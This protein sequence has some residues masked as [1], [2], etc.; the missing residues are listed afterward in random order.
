MPRPKYR[1]PAKKEHTEK[2]ESFNFGDAW[3]R[4]S[5]VSEY[6]PHGSRMPSR[7]GSLMSRKSFGGRSMRSIGRPSLARGDSSEGKKSIGG[8]AVKDEDSR[9]VESREM[10]ENGP[11]VKKQYGVA[12]PTR[13]SVEVEQEGDDDVANGKIVPIRRVLPCPVLQSL[14]RQTGQ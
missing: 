12:R 14:A 8:G 1:A 9:D 2:L 11:P 7:R 13:L 3:R 10:T 5:F 6:S 4:R